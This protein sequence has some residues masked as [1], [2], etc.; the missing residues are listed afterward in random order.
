MESEITGGSSS[1]SAQAASP[2]AERPDVNMLHI[3]LVSMLVVVMG[4]LILAVAYLIGHLKERRRRSVAAP[5]SS[6]L[7]SLVANTVD[8]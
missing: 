7:E 5:A 4:A 8:L 1:S 6:A 2:V 3:F